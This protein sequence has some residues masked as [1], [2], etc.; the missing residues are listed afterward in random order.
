MQE[1]LLQMHNIKHSTEPLVKD[2]SLKYLVIMLL[3]WPFNWDF[4]LDRCPF[5]ALTLLVGW[6]KGHLVG[7]NLALASLEISSLG[8]RQKLKVAVVVVVVVASGGGG[9]GGGLILAEFHPTLFSVLCQKPLYVFVIAESWCSYQWMQGS[10]WRAVVG[11]H[12]LL[13]LWLHWLNTGHCCCRSVVYT[14]CCVCDH[15]SCTTV[16][17]LC[18]LYMGQQIVVQ[19]C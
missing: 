9:G 17:L 4:S 15:R 5:S 6:Q 19:D 11:S 16:S 2:C 1:R 10:L 18:L 8:D 7:K 12:W 14:Q 13:W 3:S